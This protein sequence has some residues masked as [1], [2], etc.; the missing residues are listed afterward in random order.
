MG[1][2]EIIDYIE[3]NSVNECGE[4]PHVGLIDRLK[5]SLYMFGVFNPTH[6]GVFYG[7]QSNAGVVSL[8]AVAPYRRN[9]RVFLIHGTQTDEKKEQKAKKTIKEQ[10]AKSHEF[11]INKFGVKP[12][13]Y[14]A[15]EI[16]E[17]ERIKVFSYSATSNLLYPSLV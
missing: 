10:I 17:K 6:V 13:S 1:L 2:D 14:G 16:M 7:C 11:F 15:L 8:V 3:T 5:N 4:S 12:F 9:K